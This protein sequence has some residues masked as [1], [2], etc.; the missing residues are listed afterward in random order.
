M[1]VLSK[2]VFSSLPVPEQLGQLRA[3][4]SKTRQELILS[5]RNS[6]TLVRSLSPEM[7]FYTVK[8]IGLAD[9][10]GLVALAAPEQVRD[11]IDLDCWRKDHLDDRRLIAWLLLLD[12]S[13]SGKLAQWAL[14]ADIELLVLLV[15][16]HFEIVRKAEIEEDIHFDQSLY[17]TFDDQ[18]LLRFIGEEEPILHLLLERLRVLDY[19]M[20]TYILENSLVELESSLEEGAFRWRTAR[21]AD[22]AYPDYEEAQELFSPIALDTI[23]LER[24]RRAPLR[25]LRFAEGEDLIPSDHA[26]MLL[27]V[28]H[29]LFVHALRAV[30]VEEIELIG[31]ELAVLTNKA[32]IAEGVDLGEL[33]EVHRCVE[34]VHDYVNIGLAFLAQENEDQATQFLRG[35]MLHPF[36]QVGRTLVL[37]LG[38]E[39]KRLTRTLQRGSLE[40]WESLLDSP[41]RETFTGVQRKQPLFFRGLEVP[42]EILYRRFQAL[43]DID[44]V[45]HVLEQIP[46][47]FTVMQHWKLLPDRHVPEGMTLATLWNTA[48]VHWALDRQVNPQP[49][50]RK[51]LIRV[52]K[53]LSREKLETSLAVFVS[54]LVAECRFPDTQ[55]AEVQALAEFACEKLQEVLAMDVATVPLRFVTGLHMVAE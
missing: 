28:S 12:E 20:F 50:Q 34:I 37:Q 15:R 45:A 40:H 54:L 53:R 41:F 26:L 36:F 18:Y 51:D 55:V 38:Q 17:F 47:W 5:A 21:L 49:L 43:S 11:M 22:R 33:S 42:G 10:V 19:R 48:F 31:L 2:D 13:G 9:A 16:R 23:R 7:L 32:A 6:F 35:T 27:D 14:Q 24:F 25:R 8:D 46:V 44:R 29:S 1:E 3:V 4:D 52:Q 30:P 39:A